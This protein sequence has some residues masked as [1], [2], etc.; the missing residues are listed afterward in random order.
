MTFSIK[1][2]DR[3]PDYAVKLVAGGGAID[4]TGCTVKFLMT[5]AK[6]AATPKVSALAVVD[7]ALEG[8][9]H[10]EFAEGDT[11]TSGLFKTEWEI[12]Y[13]GGLARTVPSGDYAFIRVVDD[14]G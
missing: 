11:D 4:L 13:P 14:L 8:L 9:V 3:K 12:A 10:F 5:P 6:G 7:D 1:R 2:N